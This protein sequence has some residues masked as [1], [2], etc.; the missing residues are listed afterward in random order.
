MAGRNREPWWHARSG[1]LVAL[2]IAIGGGWL[3]DKVQ[4]TRAT[5]LVDHMPERRDRE[6]DQVHARLAALEARCGKS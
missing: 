3:N 6:I 4:A 5:T 2:A 1:V